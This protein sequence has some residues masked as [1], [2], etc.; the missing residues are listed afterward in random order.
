MHTQ[1]R[2]CSLPAL[3]PFAIL[4]T[5]CLTPWFLVM[6]NSLSAAHVLFL[7]FLFLSSAFN[8][9]FV[10]SMCV[11]A[12]IYPLVLSNIFPNVLP[13]PYCPPHLFPSSPTLLSPRIWAPLAH[14][15][16]SEVSLLTQSQLRALSLLSRPG[17][18]HLCGVPCHRKF[19]V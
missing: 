19:L 16:P 3:M 6:V 2:T 5:L 18:K 17:A 7:V 9:F 8:I 4:C 11:C 15:Q 12:D 10:W 1:M 13:C 14:F